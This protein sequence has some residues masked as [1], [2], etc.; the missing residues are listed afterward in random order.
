M[1]HKE[2]IMKNLY[3]EIELQI[4]RTVEYLASAVNA[5]NPEEC[6]ELHRQILQAVNARMELLYPQESTDYIEASQVMLQV[7]DDRTGRVYMRQ[8]P[9]DYRENSNGLALEGEDASGK[10]A[11]IVFFSE[12]AAGKITDITGHG[13]EHSHCGDTK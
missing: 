12:T 9:L 1:P 6:G 8:L 5:E 3:E 13:E 2:G 10:P 7:Q 11:K 4:A